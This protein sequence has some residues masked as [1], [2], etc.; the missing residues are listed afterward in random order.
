VTL[1]QVVRQRHKGARA[2]GT[3]VGVISGVIGG[4]YIAAKAAGHTA[5]G[6]LATWTGLVTAGSVGGYMVGKEID[7]Q[8]T[9]ITVIE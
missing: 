7:K 1:L 3:T 4:G 9:Y 2:I 8:T 5:G 6:F